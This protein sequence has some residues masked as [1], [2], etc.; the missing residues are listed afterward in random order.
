MKA[1]T[2]A[3][4]GAA[5][6][7]DDAAGFVGFAGVAAAVGTDTDTD[8][9]VP[10][11]LPR[12]RCLLHLLPNLPSRA[13]LGTPPTGPLPPAQRTLPLLSPAPLLG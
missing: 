10:R 6:S 1:G 12:F 11:T 13:R 2:P 7:A 4:A 9:A 8:I 5:G 3:A